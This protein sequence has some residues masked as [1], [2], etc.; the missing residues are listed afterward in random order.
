MQHGFMRTYPADLRHLAS[1]TARPEGRGR[2][3]APP[4]A[5]PPPGGACRPRHRACLCELWYWVFSYHLILLTYSLNKK[6][7]SRDRGRRCR[8]G[9]GGCR[10][11]H[12]W[13]GGRCRRNRDGLLS[14]GRGGW[15]LNRWRLGACRRLLRAGQVVSEPEYQ[16]I[17]WLLWLLAGSIVA[18]LVED[19]D[20]LGLVDEVAEAQRLWTRVCGGLAASSTEPHAPERQRTNGSCGFSLASSDHGPGCFSRR[21]VPSCTAQG[22]ASAS[23]SVTSPFERRC[24]YSPSLSAQGL[25]SCE[26]AASEGGPVSGGTGGGCCSEAWEEGVV[27]SSSVVGVATV[28]PPPGTIAQNRWPQ[29]R[30]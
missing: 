3:G 28:P 11:R 24:R 16:R 22:T 4:P 23:G 14:C 1:G 21:Y 2:G 18:A 27:F 26:S 13:R 6:Q 5:R 17:L 15:R 12:H 10:W 20:G 9:L 8:S 7:S 19:F 29:R 25:P 30:K